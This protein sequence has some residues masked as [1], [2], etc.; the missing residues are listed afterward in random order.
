MEIWKDFSGKFKYYFVNFFL[1]A[2]FVP[3]NYSIVIKGSGKNDDSSLLQGNF[4][5]KYAPRL[6]VYRIFTK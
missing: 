3:M 4:K 1:P 2:Y 5:E 6:G